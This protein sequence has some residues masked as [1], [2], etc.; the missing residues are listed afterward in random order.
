MGANPIES[1]LRAAKRTGSSHIQSQGPS[2]GAA[3]PAGASA[4]PLA[5]T[6]ASSAPPT[7]WSPVRTFVPT[8]VAAGIVSGEPPS[9]AHFAPASVASATSPPAVA[10]CDSAVARKR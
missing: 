7:R 10:T 9:Y 4:E 1:L 5:D 8:A 3:L 6:S 2:S